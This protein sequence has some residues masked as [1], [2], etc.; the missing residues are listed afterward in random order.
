MSASDGKAER[1][2][3]R[4]TFAVVVPSQ[5]IK[6]FGQR[7]RRAV[8]VYDGNDG[9]QWNTGAELVAGQWTDYFMGVILEGLAYD[10]RRPI[11]SLI[12]R[13]L[14]DPLIFQVIGKLEQPQLIEVRLLRDAWRG[15]N[16][17]R[18]R[19]LYYVDR[20]VIPGTPIDQLTKELWRDALSR[21]LDCFDSHGNSIYRQLTFYNKLTDQP[22]AAPRPQ[23]YEMTPHLHFRTPL[24]QHTPPSPDARVD[25]MRSAQH[26]LQPLYAF[27]HERSV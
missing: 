2:L 11:R 26:R 4:A 25:A 21:V 23:L 19:P 15:P 20:F 12:Q 9:V 16:P 1:E 5:Q 10:G 22:E 18:G 17:P 13:E 24:W 14:E 3:L 6:P 7:G 8:G 27:V